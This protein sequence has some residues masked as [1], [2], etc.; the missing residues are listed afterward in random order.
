MNKIYHQISA[1]LSALESENILPEWRD[2]WNDVLDR[3]EKKYLPSG[4]GFDNG[5]KID[6]GSWSRKDGSFVL[7]VDFHHMSEHGYYTGWTHHKVAVHPHLL[8]VYDLA[9][10]GRDQN[11]IKE[12]ISETLNYALDEDY[13]EEA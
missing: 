12:Y 1:A 7:L 5:T 4:S 11:G 8:W 2:R 9:V 13:K 10:G 6:R 3:I